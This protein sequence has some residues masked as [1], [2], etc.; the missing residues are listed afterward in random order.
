M[1]NL[2][3]KIYWVTTVWPK[4]QIIIPSDVRADFGINIWNNYDIAIIDDIAIWLKTIKDIDISKEKFIIDERW[5]I[6]IWTKYQF[7]IPADIRKQLEINPWDNLIILCAS[8]RWLWL[9]KNDNI[10]FLLNYLNK[11]LNN[12]N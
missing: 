5:E 7:V 10:D 3:I 8:E 1:C 4:W 6:S 11:T 12:K 2:P 9:I